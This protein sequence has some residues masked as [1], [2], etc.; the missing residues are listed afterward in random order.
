MRNLPKVGGC[1][2]DHFLAGGGGM[3]G[4]IFQKNKRVPVPRSYTSLL[5]SFKRLLHLSLAAD[6]SYSIGSF[7]LLSWIIDKMVDHKIS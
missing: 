3:G 7:S 5:A 1:N 2:F 6:S 4:L